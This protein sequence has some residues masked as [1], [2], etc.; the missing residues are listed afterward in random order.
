MDV[1]FLS[2]P[3][4]TFLLISPFLLSGCDK[5]GVKVDNSQGTISVSVTDAPIDDAMEVNLTFTGVS[6]KRM[7][8]FPYDIHFDEPVTVNLL[9]YQGSA[10]R[11]IKSD[12]K[13]QSGDYEYARLNI[14]LD[15]SNIVT[16]SGTYPFVVPFLAL[17]KRNLQLFFTEDS[18]L[19]NKSFTVSGSQNTDFI[20]DI[21][22]RKSIYVE[23][24]NTYN[25]IPSTRTLIR[26][27]VG[28]ITGTLATSL[29][30][31]S[32]CA[33]TGI[34]GKSVYLFSG[35]DTTPQ[36]IQGNGTDPFTTANI[37]G[38]SSSG[39]AYTIGFI[40]AGDYTVAFTCNADIDNI[41]FPNPVDFMETANVSVIAT[42]QTT[43]DM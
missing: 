15:S 6:I 41:N 14:D 25:F 3:A 28:S 29:V 9:D 30:D 43:Q 36:D 23:D 39:Y 2:F 27:D 38:D 22:L 31:D 13:L 1:R 11:T 19:Y 17:A 12:I 40:P 18:L 32:S 21:D 4:I 35:T 20:V 24:G 5:N 8:V 10:S 33:D 37:T 34:D 26:S 16:A 7:G 42:A